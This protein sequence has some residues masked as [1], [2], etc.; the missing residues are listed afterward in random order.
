MKS[1]SNNRTPHWWSLRWLWCWW[2]LTPSSF[3]HGLGFHSFILPLFSSPCR[4]FFCDEDD[5]IYLVLVADH[6]P[7][8][9]CWLS[10]Y[11]MIICRH[12]RVD[13]TYSPFKGQH[14][15]HPED[16]ARMMTLKRMVRTPDLIH[17]DRPLLTHET[18]FTHLKTLILDGTRA[19]TVTSLETITNIATESIIRPTRPLLPHFPIISRTIHYNNRYRPG[20]PSSSS[21][22]H[23]R[24]NN[25][26]GVGVDQ[27]NV[28]GTNNRDNSTGGGRIRI[29]FS[30][31]TKRPKNVPSF[32][33]LTP[34]SVNH[35]TQPDSV[36]TDTSFRGSPTD[37]YSSSSH[38]AIPPPRVS[39]PSSSHDEDDH[40]PISTGNDDNHVTPTDPTP[41]STPSSSSS[42]T[43][44]TTTNPVVTIPIIMPSVIPTDDTFPPPVDPSPFLP[45]FRSSDD[46]EKNAS[47][48]IIASAACCNSKSSSST[49][50]SG[51]YPLEISSPP[52]HTIPS[53]N[54]DAPFL[55]KPITPTPVT[56]YTTFTYFT[57][58]LSAG[59]TIVKS[60]E[61]IISTVIRGKVLP[62]RVPRLMVPMM[63]RAKLP[64]DD[65][66]LPG[67]GGGGWRGP[68]WWRWWSSSR[69]EDYGEDDDEDASGEWNSNV[70]FS[71]LMSQKWWS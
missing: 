51:S 71:R 29:P 67:W 43:T 7:P 38:D 42:S 62:T 25:G 16:E 64:E 52:H 55:L 22:S 20:V 30:I 60:R 56:Y 18:T 53:F 59:Q 57:T 45:S 23:N 31:V 41:S 48:V 24:M 37:P 33:E 32:H 44:S 2:W 36:R 65:P 27:R 46:H 61:Q 35:T 13:L 50:T 12:R 34:Q 8:P 5:V 39:Q 6:H 58:E 70:N 19:T 4:R 17:I 9:A 26:N 47:R 63:M 69:S 68:S 49:S 66:R 40:N 14:G 54:P 15:N 3:P 28:M 1:S 11:N 10:S 21:S